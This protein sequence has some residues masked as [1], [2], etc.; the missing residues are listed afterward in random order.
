MPE[1]RTVNCCSA[2]FQA[3]IHSLE[4]YDR[5]NMYG[6]NELIDNAIN[7]RLKL[8]PASLETDELDLRCVETRRLDCAAQRIARASGEHK[9][10]VTGTQNAFST[11]QTRIAKYRRW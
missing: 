5:G 1:F 6:I 8:A 4:W 2:A 7:V 11:T 9:M 3:K 10:P